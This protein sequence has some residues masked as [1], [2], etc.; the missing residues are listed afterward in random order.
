MVLCTALLLNEFY[1]CVKFPVPSFYT[2]GDMLQTKIQSKNVQRAITPK[3]LKTEHW[4]LCT[5][6]FL[7]EFYLCVKFQV[8]S[9]HTFG[10]MLRTKIPEKKNV[11]R[12]IT[13]KILKIE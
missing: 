9:L 3:I 5:A 10:D 6:C 2:F 12:A 4:I 13:P 1:I 7:D 8:P 11:Q